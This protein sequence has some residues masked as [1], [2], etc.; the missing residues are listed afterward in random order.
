MACRNTYKINY[1]A[2]LGDIDISKLQI[3]K[4]S[5]PETVSRLLFGV[6]SR[7]RSDNLLQN[8][9]DQFEWVLKNKIYP[10]FWGRE[11]LGENA[12]TKEEIDFLHDKGCKI[13]L[14]CSCSGNTNTEED[15]MALARKVVEKADSLGIT[16]GTA[17]FMVISEDETVSKACMCGYAKVLML[18]GFAPGFKANTDAKFS[19]DREFC[20]GIQSN[21]DIFDKCLIWAVSP[22]LPEYDRMTD[23]HLIHPDN[24]TPFAPS[25]ISRKEIAIWQYG[26]NCHPICDNNDEPTSFNLDLVRNEDVIIKK[27]F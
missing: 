18:A 1:N 22:S 17:I 14:F 16:E 6:N 2:E 11:L 26:R 8:N 10:N 20:R 15:G 24:W 9:V 23:A 12:I 21:K 25:A 7:T 5:V 13:A 19:F 27:M 4:H 3:T